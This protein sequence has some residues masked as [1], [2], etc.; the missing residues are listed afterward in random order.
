MKLPASGFVGVIQTVLGLSSV[1]GHI[2]G[3]EATIQ[4]DVA[5]I[6]SWAHAEVKTDLAGV[7]WPWLSYKSSPFTPPNSTISGNGG[8]LSEGYS[9]I[10]PSGSG[11]TTKQSAGFILTTT[12]DLV[13]ALNVTGLNDF[14]KQYF[15]GK[16]YLTYWSGY[17]SVTPNVGHGYGQVTF[18]SDRYESFV[19]DP[20]LP[21]NKLTNSTRVTGS[22]DFHEQQLTSRNTIL[23]T[24]YNNTQYDLTAVNASSK[25]W[26][27]DAVVF[28]LNVTTGEV[29]FEWRASD[30]VPLTASKQ[31]IVSS[32]G[33]ATKAAP[34]DWFHVNSIELVGENYLINSR[35]HWAVY[36]VSGKTGSVI[37]S[38]QGEDGG[39]F[40]KLP[41]DGTFR[42][43]H[44]AR[45]HNVTESGL[46][47]SL[48][49]NH[50]QALDNGTGTTKT[51]VYHLELPASKNYVP[52]LKRRI[53]TK[54]D[55][56]YAASQGSYIA[57]LP[58]GNQFVG[59]G[60][61]AVSREYGPATDG[62][63]LRWQAQFGGLNEVQSYRGFKETWHATPKDWDPSLV[64]ENDTAYVSWNG[65]TDVTSWDVYTG[66][67]TSNANLSLA[68][69]AEKKGFETAF[70]VP[71]GVKVV[72]VA[73]SQT[74]ENL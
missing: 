45:A 23:I 33:N 63:D 59:Y 56:L 65:A 29:L 32:S 61:L 51:L 16:P 66:Q 13:F 52:V 49:D 19:V 71:R 31:P 55:P 39:S 50:N 42:W 28:E 4:D 7:T 26:I 18:L 3:S 5:H 36:L 46:D 62:S 20:S 41:Q 21:I 43:Q 60:Q 47:L 40:G 44:F 17:N 64:V 69:V 11:N 24:T 14:R 58:N 1:S 9:F 53:E 48:F 2:A 72:Q 54:S 30:H 38:L 67:D 73:L 27:A 70:G 34:W 15:D 35:H 10:T 68:G 37:W 74:G 12:G 6:S 22:V 57:D 8:Q 25:G